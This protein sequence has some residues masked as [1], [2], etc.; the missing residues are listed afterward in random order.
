NFEPD[1]GSGYVLTISDLAGKTVKNIPLTTDWVD[2]S[3]L[4]GGMFVVNILREGQLVF[5]SKLVVNQ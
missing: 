2:I 3:D 1:L 4:P 5:N